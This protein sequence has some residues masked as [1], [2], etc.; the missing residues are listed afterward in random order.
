MRIQYLFA[1]LVGM[2]LLSGCGRGTT[3][4]PAKENATA[5]LSSKAD[6]KSGPTGGDGPL[7]MKFVVLPKDTFYLGGGGGVVGKKTQ[8]KYDF[9]VAVHTATQGQWQALRGNNPSWISREGGGK[10][11]VKDISDADLKQFPVELVSWQQTQEFIKK[12]NEKEHGRGFLYRLPTQE[13]WEYACRGGATS[14]EECSYHYYFAGSSGFL[15][16]NF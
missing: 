11:R 13:E 16:G 8:I 2:P 15:V 3:L 7:G 1:V 14:E 5:D 9:E 12:L 4:A 6:S 10:D